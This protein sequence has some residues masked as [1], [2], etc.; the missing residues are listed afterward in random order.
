MLNHIHLNLARGPECPDGS[1]HH[2]YEIF[3]PLD[4]NGYLDAEAWKLCRDDCTVKRFWD[5]EADHYGYLVHE[6]GGFGG[7]TWKIN[8][9]GSDNAAETAYHLDDHRFIKDEYIS[10]RSSDGEMHVFKI[11]KIQPVRKSLQE[12]S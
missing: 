4:E 9:P 1:E 3:A 7:A 2:G 6:A 12:A 5:Q 8:Y 10:I 11:S